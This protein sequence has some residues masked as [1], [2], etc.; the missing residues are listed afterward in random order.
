MWTFCDA[1]TDLA[2]ERT[3]RNIWTQE[4]ERAERVARMKGGQAGYEDERKPL[5]T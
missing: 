2:G 1:Q 5:I 4:F 3:L